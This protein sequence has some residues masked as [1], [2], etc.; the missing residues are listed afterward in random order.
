MAPGRHLPSTGGCPGGGATDGTREVRGETAEGHGQKC[1]Q[2]GGCSPFFFKNA[3]KCTKTT[4]VLR[5]SQ[6]KPWF[7]CHISWSLSFFYEEWCFFVIRLPTS[8]SKRAVTNLDAAWEEIFVS[9]CSDLQCLFIGL[10]F[11]VCG[12]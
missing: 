12:G 6:V 4:Y 3:G 8:S 9:Y 7:S 11:L 2:S 10:F 5:I 1:L